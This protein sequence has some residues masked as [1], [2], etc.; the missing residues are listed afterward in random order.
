MENNLKKGDLV[1]LKSG[2][3]IMTVKHEMANGTWEC[4]WFDKA[5]VLQFG[6]FTAPQLIIQK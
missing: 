5:Q 1:V 2:G 6:Y 4:S 3:P